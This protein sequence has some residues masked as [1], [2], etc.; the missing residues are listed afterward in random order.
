MVT[1]SH[2]QKLGRFGNQLWQIAAT[3]GY[4]R[5][6]QKPYVLPRWGYATHFAGEIVQATN[7]PPA[8]IYREPGF[9]YTRI[10]R[11]NK[12]D[13]Y[14]YFQSRRYWQ[15]CEPEIRKTFKPN[16]A[17]QVMIDK[18]RLAESDKT[19]CAVHVRRTDYL[20]QGDYHPVQP[21]EYYKKAIESIPADIYRIFSDDLEWCKENINEK[22]TSGKSFEYVN[23]GVDLVDFFVM[24]ECDHFII[25]NSSFSWWA[26]YLSEAANKRIIAPFKDRWFG[27]QYRQHNVDDLYLKEW[28]LI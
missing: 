5:Q 13:L 9:H 18:N 14:G 4:A 26:S 15:H 6:Y 10:P 16:E 2:L 1:F 19:I 7:I 23:S 8:S 17:I 12:V 27:L 28:E 25:A 24:A 21:L 3:I 22:T 20:T 11:Y